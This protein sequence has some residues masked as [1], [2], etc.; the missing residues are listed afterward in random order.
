MTIKVH[1]TFTIGRHRETELVCQSLLL[2]NS[3]ESE[4]TE[5]EPHN[6]FVKGPHFTLFCLIMHNN[7]SRVARARESE[8]AQQGQRNMDPLLQQVWNL[9]GNMYEPWVNKAFHIEKES[10]RL[11]QSNVLEACS[12]TKWYAVPVVWLPV[13]TAC[14]FGHGK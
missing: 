6:T 8:Q 11:F 10:K 12:R 1:V 2:P 9:N 5:C 13:S 14:F 3:V 7:Q 4:L